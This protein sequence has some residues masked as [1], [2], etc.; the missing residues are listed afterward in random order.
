MINFKSTKRT[1]ASTSV[2]AIVLFF[3]SILFS[4]VFSGCTKSTPE[5]KRI[6]IWTSCAE[7]AQYIELFNSSHENDSAVLVYKENPA[8]SLPPTKDE[9]PPDIVVG[10][11]LRNNVTSRN[12]K[13]LEYLF[14]RKNIVSADFYPQ[15]LESGKVNNIQYLLP[16]SFNLPAI[17]FSAQN[18]E[19][20]TDNYILNL[21]SLRKI[22]SDYNRKN[23]KEVYTRIGFTPLSND[24][25][26]Y[27]ATK[28]NHS[29]FRED[30]GQIVWNEDNLNA[31]IASL[32]DWITV[33]N[34]SASVEQDF[35]FKYLSM[36]D[37]R[38]V[39]SGRTLFAYTTSDSL[40]NTVSKQGLELDYR[41]L[42]SNDTEKPV[43]PME[44]NYMMMGIYKDARNQVGASEFITWFFQT[45]NQ[46][47][48]IE[49][50][51]NLKLDTEIFGIAGGFSSIREVTEHVLPVFYT[52]MLSNL[53]PVAMIEIP[54]KLPARW[55]SYKSLVVEPYIKQ[56]IVEDD[57][58]DFPS[59]TNL[60]AEWR[61]KVF[62]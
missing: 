2:K 36:P 55:D 59:L 48:I 14:D 38:Q 1:I 56:S 41:W 60:E 28:I 54:E 8:L 12:F 19:L 29:E 39:T 25:F 3:M 26:L 34:T 61:N 9:L 32:K 46:K 33:E 58:S 15:L 6:V 49:R 52:Q 42:S 43:I 31:S 16:V 35:S 18:K 20:I 17:I 45:E 47:R 22:A 30:K 44:D 21:D 50:K 4:L 51:S 11:W 7:F 40:F 13:R 10:S 62:D 53:P 23:K 24:A 5:K 37:Y 57:A 27:F